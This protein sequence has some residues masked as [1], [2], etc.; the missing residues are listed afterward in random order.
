MH[1]VPVIACYGLESA[2]L[3]KILASAILWQPMVFV[4][5]HQDLAEGLDVLREIAC[6]V[7][8]LEEY[9]WCNCRRNTGKKFLVGN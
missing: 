6:L 1:G 7:N 8:S 5:H 3:E 2:V 9:E 4:G